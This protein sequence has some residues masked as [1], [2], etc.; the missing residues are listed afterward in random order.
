MVITRSR[1]HQYLQLYLASQPLKCVK[2]YKYLGDIITS[3]LTLSPV[4]PECKTLTPSVNS[5]CH[6]SGH[7]S[8]YACT[9]WDPYLAKERTL[10]EAVQKFACKVC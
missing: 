1:T 7:I 8:I 6:A 9:V 5:T 3:N 2:S 4:L 10:L